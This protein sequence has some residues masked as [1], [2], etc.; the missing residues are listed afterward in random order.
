MTVIVR[1]IGRFAVG[2]LSAAA[3]AATP[4]ALAFAAPVSGG[5]LHDARYCEILE[6]K[7]TP[8]TAR[9]IVW[10][11]IGLNDCPAKWWTAL[12]AASLANE[13][14]D[15]AVVL[16]G[17]R[18][19]LMDSATAVTGRTRSFH[20]ERLTMV[21]S[22]PIRSSADL[23]QTPYLDRTISRTNTWRWNAG[24]T[25]F[26]LVAP[27]GDIYVMQSYAQIKDPALTL[28]RLSGLGRRLMLPAG[29]Q[30]RSVTLRRP[31]VLVAR[32]QA[33]VIQDEFQDTYQ[34]AA[35]TRPLGR[36]VRRGIHI[37]GRTRE[38]HPQT[39]GTI[40]DRGRLTGT[41]FGGG[42]IVLVV[43]VHNGLFEGTFR[44]LFA[45]G[46]I[47][48]NASLPFTISGNSI[49]FAGTAHFTGGTG[50]YRG[51]TSGSLDVHDHNT[52]DG[53]HGVLT[54]DGFATY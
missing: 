53:Q 6:V 34:L 15:T 36:R 48:G 23:N 52:L 54:V 13:L 40:E 2:A 1:R 20:G 4:A 30:Y 37:D 16:N 51:I 43:R 10:N 46:S 45:G 3:V 27:G 47:V 32:K 50:I 9:A 7:G 11:T 39:P 44:L 42:S 17:P 31:L 21:A 35:S 26:E 22:V 19:F 24:R 29:W 28:G 25:A 41:P 18:H 8:P 14:G 5:N 12:K 49:T 33:T 38:V